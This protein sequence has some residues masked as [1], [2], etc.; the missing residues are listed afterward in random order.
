MLFLEHTDNTGC[1][2]FLAP[3]IHKCA[4]AYVSP[5]L[6]RT[7]ITALEANRQPYAEAQEHASN[8]IVIIEVE[9]NLW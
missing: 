5:G 7:C 2:M 4:C 6:F 3:T 9:L 8:C 1:L